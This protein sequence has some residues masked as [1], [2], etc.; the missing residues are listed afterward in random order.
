VTKRDVVFLVADDGM[1]QMLLGFFDRPQ[2]HRRLGCGAFDFD[3][4][5]D[6]VVHPN[7]DPGVY[8]TARDLLGPYERSHERAVVMVDA[9]WNGSPGVKAIQHHIA[10]S[11]ETAWERFAVVV[12]EPE[13]EAWVWQDNPNIAQALK[14][15]AD[16]RKILAASGHWPAGTAKPPDPKAALQ[17]LQRRHRAD[18]SKAAF[19]RLA[20]KV[21][22]RGCQDPAF[23]QLCDAL[24]AWFPE[25]R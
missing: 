22:T 16:F 20:A 23:H 25:A 10:R 4:D 21:S 11:L 7:K 12:I 9:A 15:P 18:G 8:H 14:C 3:A 19:R 5:E 6:I 1:R 17:H 13:L 2:P 24:H